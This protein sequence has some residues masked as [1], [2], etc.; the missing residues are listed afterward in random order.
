MLSD[1]ELQAEI[2][3]VAKEAS[4][5]VAVEGVKSVD[6]NGGPAAAGL[7]KMVHRLAPRIAGQDMGT[8]DLQRAAKVL[9][10]NGSQVMLV[11][12]NVLCT[13]IANQ[14]GPCTRKVGRP[15]VGQCQVACDHRL[16]LE[17]AKA[18]HAKAI[19]Q[20]LEIA[21]SIRDGLERAWWVGQLRTHL[22]PFPDLAQAYENDVRV[23]ALLGEEAPDV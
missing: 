20:I 18:D 1:P 21:P 4:I 19:E 10:R 14:A 2:R 23:L 5:A 13:K 15:D 6:G 8:E 11:R 3:E 12:R 7:R 16:E 9:S 17:A 22:S